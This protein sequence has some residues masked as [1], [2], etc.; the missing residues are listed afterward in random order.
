M[1][2]ATID[3]KTVLSAANVPV[4]AENILARLREVAATEAAP[5]NNLSSY[6]PF[7]RLVSLLF[8]QPVLWLTQFLSDEILPALFLQTAKG[9][10]VDV[11]AWQLGL[12]RK[13]A[14]KARGYITITRYQA[15]A[16]QKVPIGT[17]IQS[18]TIAGRVYRLKTLEDQYFL[19]GQLE[20]VVLCE[21]EEAGSV[22]NLATGFYALVATQLAG[23]VGARNAENWLQTPGADEETDEELKARCR[24]QFAAVNHWN[25]DAVYKGLIS[26]YTSVSVNDLYIEHDAPRGAGTANIYILSD[27]LA[28]SPAWYAA[29]T[30]R[31][32][33]DGSHG[34]GD[35]VLVMPIPTRTIDVYAKVRLAGWL[36]SSQQANLANNIHHFIAVALRGLPVS[37]GYR[38]TRITPNILFAWSV[39]IKELHQQFPELLSIDFA[40]DTDLLPEL[41]VTRPNT[42]EIEVVS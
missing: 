2:G 16:K 9:H 18:P 11:F 23:I 24:N 21:A 27:E 5:F 41:W 3:F 15:G 36:T 1:S 31:I 7:W 12:T 38:P 19:A 35:D 13:L 28:T 37:I 33:Q 30:N 42:I 22:Y 20:L 14:I 29:I 26:Y 8:V 40:N 6:S 34:L 4:T 10:W 39:L 17:V 25:V 32:K